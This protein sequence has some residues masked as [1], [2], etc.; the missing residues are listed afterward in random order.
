MLEETPDV[1]FE[2][3]TFVFTGTM[4]W[5]SRS[6]AEKEIVARGGQMFKTRAMKEIDYLVLGEHSETGW[7]SR[8]SG[9]KLAKAFTY[10]FT[11]P[12]GRLKI[13]RERDFT[14]AL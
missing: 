9:P 11:H 2:G 6:D 3:E 1:V 7:L 4:A 12:Q 5:G 10:K 14:A 8:H 13:I